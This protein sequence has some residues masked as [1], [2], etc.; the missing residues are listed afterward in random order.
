MGGEYSYDLV[1]HLTDKY[2]YNKILPHLDKNVKRNSVVK[3]NS[4]GF[5]F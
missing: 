1:K 2:K 5:R 3:M 4:K